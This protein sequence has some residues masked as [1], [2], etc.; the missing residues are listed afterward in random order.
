MD[1]PDDLEYS[2]T[3]EWLR[4]EGENAIVGISDHAQAELSGVVF[5][6]LP[7]VGAQVVANQPVAVVK[8]AQAAI[9]VYSPISGT[10]IAVNSA[11]EKNPSLVNTDPYGE[12]W[13][14][15]ILVEAGEEI[16]QLM[17]PATYKAQFS[18][19]DIPEV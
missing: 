8:S 7:K 1:V 11:L 3:H 13:I 2:A 14:Y 5:V 10:I 15:N 9:E 17:D 16:E 12:G 18:S 19:D 6:G 4:L